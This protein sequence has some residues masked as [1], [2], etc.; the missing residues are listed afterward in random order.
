MKCQALLANSVDPD[1]LPHSTVSDLGLYCSGL[2][3]PI[4]NTRAIIVVSNLLHQMKRGHPVYVKYTVSDQSEI[5]AH[6]TDRT[7]LPNHV[8]SGYNGQRYH[9]AWLKCSIYNGVRYE[10]HSI[11]IWKKYIMSRIFS[12]CF[13]SGTGLDWLICWFKTCQD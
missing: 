4:R 10:G 9:L 1:Q 12:I 7:L 3:V 11:S 5:C 2:T 8:L 13:L 6:S